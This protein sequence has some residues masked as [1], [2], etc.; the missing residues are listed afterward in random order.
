MS[1]NVA[2][3]RVTPDTSFFI[4]ATD[5]PNE[6]QM[7]CINNIAVDDAGE[8]VSL[9]AYLMTPASTDDD[10]KVCS[11]FARDLIEKVLAEALEEP[12]E[13]LGA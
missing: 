11:S 13:N 9:D 5:G 2:Y 7:Y 1:D 6:G 3:K 4:V 8:N 10:R 12:T